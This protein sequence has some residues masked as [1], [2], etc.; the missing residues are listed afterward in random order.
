MSQG[1]WGWFLRS[2]LVIHVTSEH[3]FKELLDTTKRS[4]VVNFSASWC[5]PCRYI[6][7]AFHE[8]SIKYPDTIFLKV[9]VDE[10][11]TVAKSC[12]V[13]SMPTFQFFRDSVCGS[14][15]PT[16]CP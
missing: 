4:V 2:S 8:L 14:A 6:S 11:K 10:L 15:S 1:C 12:G 13:A 3:R 7:P 9:D 5:G 16:L